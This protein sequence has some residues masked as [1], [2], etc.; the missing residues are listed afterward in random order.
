MQVILTPE[1]DEQLLR[2]GYQPIPVQG[3]AAVAEY[4]QSG[5]MTSERLQALRQEHTNAQNTGLRTGNLCA[6]D[7]DVV[8]PD[9]VSSVVDLAERHFGATPLRRFGSKGLMLCY[10]NPVPIRKVTV[11]TDAAVKGDFADKVEV[12][13]QGLQFVAFGIHPGTGKPFEWIGKDEFDETATP[14]TIAL[15]ELPTVTPE[16]IVAFANDCATLLGAHGYANPRVRQAGEVERAERTAD[17][18]QDAPHNIAR[19]VEHLQGCVKRGHVAVIGALGNDTIYELACQCLD[20]FYLSEDKTA[21]LMLK[22]WY[23]HCLPNTLEDECRSIISHA[24]SY[25]QN[26]PGARAIPPAS[27]AFCEALDKLPQE[28]STPE[29][30]NADL[31]AAQQ[32]VLQDEN[33]DEDDGPIPADQYVGQEFPPLRELIPV[34]CERNV[35]TFLEGPAATQKSR[36][37]LQD[38]IALSSGLPVMG[39]QG[40]ERTECVYMNYENSPEEMARRVHLICKHLQNDNKADRVNPKGVHI[41]ELRKNPRPILTVSREK[42]VLI[43]RFGRRFLSLIATRRNAGL[44]TLVVMDGLMD[45]IIFHDNTR[46]D[47]T[48]AMSIIRLIDSWCLEYDFTCYSIV[49]P[50]RS[51]ERGATV[52]SYATAWTTKP[53]AIQTFRRVLSPFA[54]GGPK[55]KITEDTPIDDIFYQ[56][57][58]QKRSNGPEG[59][60]LLLEYWKGGLRPHLPLKKLKP[61]HEPEVTGAELED[62]HDF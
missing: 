54:G 58:V 31:G 40:C 38:A 10:R 6:L 24:A 32:I 12:L 55:A 36:A 4:W 16:K 14:L 56:R 11:L 26:E 43:T 42:G 57:R 61:Q 5:D 44:H 17:V 21:E 29:G 8:R 35:N 15:N 48:V 47:D 2:N 60:R 37:A 33:S 59:D 34:W 49:H 50:S 52:G 3:K 51:S 23:P 25:I 30:G 46:N 7:I 9:T 1:Q 13:G 19:C 53:R 41:W 39:K 18:K 22:H 62:E 28:P 45:A 20:R 27:E